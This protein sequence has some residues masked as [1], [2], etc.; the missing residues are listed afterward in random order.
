MKVRSIS[1]CGKILLDRVEI[2]A[3]TLAPTVSHQMIH[4]NDS[5]AARTVAR[6]YGKVFD[7][8]VEEVPGERSDCLQDLRTG[9]VLQGQ[10]QRMFPV[11][12]DIEDV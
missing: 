2:I 8:V 5:G 6:M 9:Y 4:I 1:P 12:D 7:F 10:L 11:T 3:F